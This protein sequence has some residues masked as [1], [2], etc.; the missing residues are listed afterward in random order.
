MKTFTINSENKVTTW[1]SR[2]ET[3]QKTTPGAA[4]FSTIDELAQI[5]REWPLARLVAVWNGLP[6]VTPLNRFTDRNTA[7]A[8]IWKTRQN[9]AEPTKVSR[10]DRGKR[11]SG[12]KKTLA[13]EG[14]KKA[15]I[16]IL[17]NRPKGA[18][19]DDIMDATGWQAHSVRGFISGNLIKRMGLKVN[20]TRRSG[21]ART[22]QIMRG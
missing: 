7:V 15:R 17:L 16:L 19:I 20:S 10:P 5:T 9:A 6:G 22:Y 8:R 1:D 3:Q 11:R 21:G 13:R 2:A 18:T 12:S 14:S 4:R